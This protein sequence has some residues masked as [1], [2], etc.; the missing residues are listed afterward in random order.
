MTLLLTWLHEYGLWVVF[1]NVLL[2]Q[3]GLPLPAVPLL[4]I[5]GAMSARGSYP[6][7]G[8][9]ATAVAA[10][11][12]ADSGWY[13]AGRRLGSRM[14]RQLCRISLSPDTCVMQTETIFGRWGA[15][16]LAFAKFAPGVGAVLTAV[17]GSLQVPYR[18]FL[19][20]DAIGALLWSGVAVTLGWLF[21][22]AV[23]GLLQQLARLGRIG[24]VAA[25]TAFALFALYKFVQRWRFRRSLRMARI[26][27][28]ELAGLMEAGR[29]PAVLDVRSETSRTR[30]GFIPG[31][32][33][34]STRAGPGQVPQL[35]RESEVVVYCACPN[36]ASAALVAKHL[37]H[38]GF[39]KVR[40]LDGGIEAWAASGRLVMH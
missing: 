26:S 31:S 15:K 14:L 13:W 16:S 30:D 8:L 4:V 34:W 38:A 2:A 5:T 36:E 33:L 40:P 28:D 17:T 18:T 10:S 7:A 27:V 25:L 12:I 29:A 9:L 11:L 23:G 24:L 37:L 20:F 19:V 39:H 1:V 21:H 32:L 6:V 22:D 3:A 35:A